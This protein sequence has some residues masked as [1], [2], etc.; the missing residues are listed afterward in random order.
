MNVEQLQKFEKKIEKIYESGRIKA[1]I[2][3]RNGNEQELIDIYL[4]ITQDAITEDDYVFSTWASHLHAILKGVPESIIEADIIKGRSITLHYPEYNFY[5][6][7][8]VGGIAPIALGVAKALLKQDK[9]SRVH[10]F[11][12]DMSFHS[13][14]VNECVRY[15]IGHAVPIT[16]IIEDNGKS[17]GTDTQPTCGIHTADLYENLRRILRKYQCER[18]KMIYYSYKCSYPHSGTGVFVEF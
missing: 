4:G 2:H 9:K 15:S 8:I 14:I 7:A 18:V 16:W 5:S 6:S 10:C 13:G 12:G 3:L 11:L 17:V 1:P